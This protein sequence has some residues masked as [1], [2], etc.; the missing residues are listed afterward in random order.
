MGAAVLDVPYGG[1][2]LVCGELA[3][4]E[5]A[6]GS[7]SQGF[8]HDLRFPAVRQHH[9]RGDPHQVRE[10]RDAVEPGHAD[11][12]E[13]DVGTVV[14]GRLAGLVAVGRLGD[15]RDVRAA[16]EQGGQAGSDHGVVVGHDD[17]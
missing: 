1:H 8:L 16:G 2:Q 4:D 5:V 6:V 14:P 9:H 10:R 13:D 15:D 11:V 17:P 7:A 3:V 12:Q